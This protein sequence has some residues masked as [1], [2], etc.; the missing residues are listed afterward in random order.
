M[1]CGCLSVFYDKMAVSVRL[2]PCTV[3]FLP[4][5][6]G[7]LKGRVTHIGRQG[8]GTGSVFFFVCM[9]CWP[10]HRSTRHCLPLSFKGSYPS[11]AF[12]APLTS[13]SKKLEMGGWDSGW[14]SPPLQ[15]STAKQSSSES[16]RQGYRGEKNYRPET[17]LIPN[18]AKSQQKLQRTLP[19]VASS[20]T[21]PPPP[22]LPRSLAPSP[23]ACHSSY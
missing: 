10:N 22:S 6:S 8:N 18:I 9:E 20:T 11:F 3:I 4:R 15:G 16:L 21:S 14:V 1:A 17:T 13:L 5:A 19:T 12:P 2:L 23:S 7:P